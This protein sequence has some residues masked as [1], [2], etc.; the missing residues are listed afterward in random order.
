MQSGSGSLELTPRLNQP[1][2]FERG[3][4]FSGAHI[5]RESATTTSPAAG[6]A[7][8]Q[9]QARRGHPASNRVAPAESAE[10]AVYTFAHRASAQQRDGLCSTMAKSTK[11]KLTRTQRQPGVIGFCARVCKRQPPPPT[12]RVVFAQAPER[13]AEFFYQDNEIITSRYTALTFPPVF[14]FQQFSRLANF[15]FLCIIVLQIIPQ[16]SITNGVPTTAIPLAFVLAFD[17]LVTGYE[18]WQRHKDDERTNSR[19][20]LVLRD[21]EFVPI[22]SRDIVVGD[23]I[24]IARE[25]EFP[26]DCVM[27][28][29]EHDDPAQRT[30]CHVQT[31]QVSIKSDEAMYILSMLQCVTSA[32]IHRSFSSSLLHFRS[33]TGRPT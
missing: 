24:K 20:Y 22:A 29:A 9:A 25:E 6:A 31:A 30:L 1:F 3:T 21:G 27:L 14:L 32:H 12:E 15:Y 11:K 7:K 26:A 28:L 18:D 16:I 23:I 10:S 5:E 13:H 4:P 2:L 8:R 17:G 19:P 33:W